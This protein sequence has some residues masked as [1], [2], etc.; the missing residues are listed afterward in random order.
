MKALVLS[1]GGAY[2]SFQAGVVKELLKVKSYDLIC[3]VSVGA[4]N[5]AFISQFDNQT[6][7][8]MRLK[9]MW[10]DI[11]TKSIYKKWFFWPI[12]VLW[13]SSIYD[14]K[15]LQNIIKKNI[16]EQKVSRTKCSIGIVCHHTGKYSNIILSDQAPDTVHGFIQASSAFPAFL[17]PLSYDDKTFYDG[18]VRNITPLS[19]AIRL[20]ADEI[21]VVMCQP[22]NI[23]R[24]SQDNPKA[25]DIAKRTLDI[26]MSEIIEND[27]KIAK[28][29]NRLI[30]S[31][32]GDEDK[33]LVPISVYRPIE[34]LPI[35]SS[36]DFNPKKIRQSL[37]IGEAMVRYGIVL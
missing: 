8:G 37:A 22:K 13:K 32:A 4:L 31:G 34:D 35:E 11:D 25:F 17:T 1:G 16:D 27:I 6:E 15:P 5:G 7:A 18:G 36:L 33:R 28:M 26:M 20:G 29:H 23:N 9:R 12:S 14:S 10:L 21:D 24:I 19:D 3:G 30:N 2:G